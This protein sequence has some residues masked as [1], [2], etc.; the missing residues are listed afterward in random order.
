M[1]WSFLWRHS[2]E[3]SW[4]EPCRVHSVARPHCLVNILHVLY[5]FISSSSSLW[6]TIVW[7]ESSWTVYHSECT[8]PLRRGTWPRASGS[9]S[10]SSQRSLRKRESFL[11][12]LLSY[13][14]FTAFYLKWVFIA[15]PQVLKCGAWLMCTKLHLCL[16]T[17][18]C[19][20]SRMSLTCVCF[21]WYRIIS[22]VCEQCFHL[23]IAMM[24]FTHL[25]PQHGRLFFVRIV[26]FTHC[27]PHIQCT[28]WQSFAFVGTLE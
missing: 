14:M 12:M 19:L 4:G 16:G 22:F 11:S 17:Q 20:F 24:I 28:V 3:P 13:A 1:L 27:I 10:D 26:I 15:F 9:V 7:L 23:C 18:T 6:W 25:L 8:P 5:L 21:R 2:S